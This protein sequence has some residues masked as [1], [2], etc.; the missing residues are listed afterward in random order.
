[1]QLQQQL[2][3]HHQER[4]LRAAAAAAAQAMT[5]PT[6]QTQQIIAH[7]QAQLAQAM[8]GAICFCP[9]N[10]CCVLFYSHNR[11]LM[12][13]TLCVRC[14]RPAPHT[15]HFATRCGSLSSSLWCRCSCLS[16]TGPSHLKS[17]LG[18]SKESRGCAEQ[19]GGAIGRSK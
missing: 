6:P 2:H 8:G 14:R 10:L 5:L 3:Q 13:L 7:Q 16:A 15:H 18:S 9:V 1:M 11:E 4:H 17:V 19:W 12:F